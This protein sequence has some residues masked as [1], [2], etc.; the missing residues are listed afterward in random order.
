[1]RILIGLRPAVRALA[2]GLS[3]AAALWGMTMTAELWWPFIAI[4]SVGLINLFVGF[5]DERE[6][7]QDRATIRSLEKISLEANERSRGFEESLE[8]VARLLPSAPPAYMQNLSAMTNAELKAAV[9]VSNTKL[10]LLEAKYRRERDCQ[11]DAMTQQMF[12][13]RTDEDHR[14]IREQ[15]DVAYHDLRNREHEEFTTSLRP[16][17]VALFDEMR[18]RIE[19]HVSLP[20]AIMLGSLTGPNP[21]DDAATEMDRMARQLPD[22]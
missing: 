16:E 14:R 13:A 12:A 1:M 7:R 15:D 5:R 10:R 19:G 6:L 9:D 8:R 4:A 11:F 22:D 2:N 21:L 17:A 20:L 3:V 18:S